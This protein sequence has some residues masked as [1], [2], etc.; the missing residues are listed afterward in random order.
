MIPSKG[1][2]VS[3]LTN[4]DAGRETRQTIADRA[5]RL[6]LGFDK[7]EPRA[8]Q[9]LSPDMTGIRGRISRDARAPAGDRAR[10]ATAHR[11]YTAAALRRRSESAT[12]C[13]HRR[14]RCRSPASTPRPCSTVRAKANASSSCATLPV[15]SNGC[16]GTAAS[17][18]NNSR[19]PDAR[20]ARAA[21]AASRLPA[22]VG[23]AIG[24]RVRQPHHAHRVAG[25]C[26][27]AR[28][29]RS[30]ADRDLSALSVI[31]GVL[32]GLFAGGFIDRR[33]KR[34]VMIWSDVVRALLVLSIPIAA[35]SAHLGIVQLYVVA[36]LVGGFSALFRLADTAYLPVLI[37]REHLVEGNS[38]LQATDSVAEIGGPGLAGVLI[39]WL[40][41]PVT[42]VIDAFS[43]VV[44][45]IVL[46]RIRTKES[47]VATVADATVAARRPA[48]R[49]TRGLWSPD[50]RRHVPVVCDRRL[51]QRLLHGAVHAVRI[52]DAFDRRRDDGH[53]DQPR[54]SGRAGGCVRRVHRIAAARS[55]SRDDRHVPD[56]QV[57]E[58]VRRVRVDRA[59]VR[60]WRGCRRAS[61][62]ATA[63]S[64][65]F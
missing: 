3:V 59:A 23:G 50:R 27:P 17:R 62:S 35:W 45:A 57:R 16:A 65:R 10:Q 42:M 38:K 14:Q 12:A 58:P 2:A 13:R 7:P 29:R 26:D 43:Y 52:A 24:Q 36:A 60:A 51:R 20:L 34:P 11:R 18:A 55:R 28:H 49:R 46:A 40:T 33:A 53:R 6:F 30:G 22:P 5:Q 56:R 21:G 4:A 41:A 48:H 54:W 15:A 39:Q 63:R 44:S 32:V 64:W 47:I 37:G 1:F 19:P 31:P 9:G 25:D 8:A 61:C